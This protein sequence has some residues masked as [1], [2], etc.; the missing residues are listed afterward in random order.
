MEVAIKIG[1]RVTE[2]SYTSVQSTHLTDL[3][4]SHWYTVAPLTGRPTGGMLA[5]SRIGVAHFSQFGGWIRDMALAGGG[6][7]A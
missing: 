5:S 4:G 6:G 1:R 2:T 3:Q 7:Q